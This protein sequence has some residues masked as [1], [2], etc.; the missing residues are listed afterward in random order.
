[1][2][3]LLRV[4]YPFL[5]LAC[6]TSTLTMQ[7]QTFHRRTQFA[8]DSLH[9][10]RLHGKADTTLVNVLLEL[11]NPTMNITGTVVTNL[12]T[13]YKYIKQAEA[14]SKSLSFTKGEIVAAYRLGYIFLQRREDNASRAIVQ[15]GI[16]LSK[17]MGDINLE[18]HGWH[19]LGDSYNGLDDKNFFEK[20]RCFYQ[21]VELFKKSGDL[22]N[23]AD[24]MAQTAEI[25][26][27]KGLYASAKNNLLHAL[28]L[29]RSMGKESQYVNECLSRTERLLENYPEA[30]KY[31]LTSLRIAL[32]NRDS[33]NLPLIHLGLGIIYSD[34][35]LDSEALTQYEAALWH[36][37]K[38]NINYL[39]LNA[40][41]LICQS[42]IKNHKTS[43]ALEYLLKMEKELPHD[44]ARSRRIL[45]QARAECYTALKQ[46]DVAEKYINE[47]LNYWDSSPDNSIRMYG[48][49]M[50]GRLY[51]DLKMYDK[52]RL[53]LEKALALNSELK[54]S[55][56]AQKQQLSLFKLDSAQGRFLSAI[57]HYQQYKTL[58][59]ALFNDKLSNQ[60]AD[61]QIKHETT[62]KEQRIE[63]LTKENQI[64]QAK[65]VQQNFRQRVGFVGSLLLMLVLAITYNRFRLKRRSNTLLQIKQDEI[66]QKNK[67]L[68]ELLGE[69]ENLLGVQGVLLEEKE[70]LLKEI[71][72]RVKNN[73]QV[74]MS[75][76]NSQ[77][78]YLK[79]DH[80]LSAIQNSQHRVYVI[81]LLHQKLYLSDRV[82]WIEMSA[83]LQ[84][85][86]DYLNECFN[87]QNRVRFKLNID[88]VELDV[89][90]AVPLALIINEAITNCLKYAFPN[91]RTG[92]VTIT[93]SRADRINYRLTINDNG[94]GT[95]KGT[96]HGG[97]LGMSLMNGLSKQ[98]GGNLQI[99]NN[100]G[101]Q[102]SV[103]FPYEENDNSFAKGDSNSGVHLRKASLS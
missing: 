83:Y 55:M 57:A 87:D 30:L 94:I 15:R 66:N 32:E 27:H 28:E 93:L 6:C 40:V 49:E 3:N 99:E 102:V 13:A 2:N 91:G 9:A 21:S 25:E 61:L 11:G 69:K 7:A 43:E 59:D 10:L 90:L 31:G 73:L 47:M 36:S 76:L 54:S 82:A 17:K 35:R 50:A 65:L 22:I 84:E 97:S 16:D 81:S 41:W 26:T 89:A 12:D 52:S 74:V 71:H 58:A 48:H 1:M 14:L 39:S 62:A 68:Q 100:S 103:L 37:R 53:H 29:C 88:P 64:Q 101:L 80:A 75:L 77:A 79:D 20:I 38:Q 98:L 56:S 72:H 18:A 96:T 63:L 51:S 19:F 8:A 45:T 23:T 46:F 44:D 4:I 33:T 92:L 86:V 95:D 42:L 24:M 85:V 78:A 67:S 5:A 70:W 60:I 34:L